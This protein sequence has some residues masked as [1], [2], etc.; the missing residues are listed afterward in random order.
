MPEETAQTNPHRLTRTVKVM[1]QRPI[2]DGNR[3]IYRHI[4][5][6]VYGQYAA[7]VYLSS[8]D[9]LDMG[10]PDTLTVTI[11]PGDQLNETTQEATCVH[12]P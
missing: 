3:V 1:H 9:Y 5:D 4:D 11:E 6:D 12:R 7:T 8:E 2:R 10:C